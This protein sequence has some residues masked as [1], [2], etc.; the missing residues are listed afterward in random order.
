MTSTKFNKHTMIVT[1]LLLLAALSPVRGADFKK[2]ISEV[3]SGVRTEARAIWWGFNP[4]DATKSLQD[5]INSGAKKIVVDNPGK[6]WIVAPVK[7]ASNQEIVFAKDVQIIAKKGLFKGK[8][9]CLFIARHKQ[10]IVL[11]GMGNVI[12]KMHKRDYADKKKYTRA[13]WRHMLSLHDV[14]NVVVKN[15]TFDGSGGDGVYVNIAEGVTLENLKIINQ[16][17]QG[18]SV[19][20]AENLMIRRCLIRDT[21]GTSP[22]AGIDFEPNGPEERL[23]N[24]VVEDCKIIGNAGNGIEFHLPSLKYTKSRPVSITIRRCDIIRNSGGINLTMTKDVKLPFKGDFK[25]I[26]CT[27]SDSRSTSVFISDAINGLHKILFKNCK[28]SNSNTKLKVAIKMTGGYAVGRPYG[29]ITFENVTVTDKRRDAS[30]FSFESIYSS[31]AVAQGDASL[32]GKPFDFKAL[33]EK[34]KGK[35]IKAIKLASNKEFKKLRPVTGQPFVPQKGLFRLRNQNNFL[36]WAKEGED[37]TLSLQN[38]KL[39]NHTDAKITIYNPDGKALKKIKLIAAQCEKY[40]FKADKTGLFRVRINGYS[41]VIVKSSHNGQGLSCY[42]SLRM[43]KPK[44][45]LY[46]QVPAGV[47]KIGVLIKGQGAEWV[48]AALVNPSGKRVMKKEEATSGALLSA[49]RADS[50]S[51]EIWSIDFINSVEDVSLRLVAPLIP[52][53]SQSPSMLLQKP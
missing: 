22:Q 35:D 24:C 39:G 15:F 33:L 52:I 45:K 16:Y 20:S 25:F 9:D 29:D 19:I 42:K 7:L 48:S 31:L 4:K 36:L 38:Q 26:D 21:A 53:V 49:I 5:A 6:P 17:R 41:M 27:I 34:E 3:K 12:F 11:T 32:N 30:V 18:I 2:E 13:E 44:G 47:K 28:I 10:N 50:S 40:T 1:S 14:K 51:S 8:N 46:F 23:V 43:V 37:I